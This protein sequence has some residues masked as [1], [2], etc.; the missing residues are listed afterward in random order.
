MSSKVSPRGVL[1]FHRLPDDLA[2]DEKLRFLASERLRGVEW[3]RLNPNA[4]HTWLRSDTEDEFESFIPIASKTARRGKDESADTIFKTYCLSMYTSRDMYVY[5]FSE[6]RLLDRMYDFIDQYNIEAFRYS[7]KNPKPEIDDF[8]SYDKIKWS[9][10]LKRE[11]ARGHFVDYEPS[12]VRVSHYRPY[13]KKWLYFDRQVNE[14]TYQQGT[15]FPHAQAELDNR[16][17]CCTDVSYRSPLISAMVVN[18]VPNMNVCSTTDAHQCFPF[19]TYDRDGSNRRENIT[20]FALARFRER[21]A[22]PRIGKWDIF[23]YVYALLHHPG[24]RARYAL[25]LKRSLP[26]LPFAPDFHAFAE[27][28]RRLADL[29]LHYERAEPYPLEWDTGGKTI[30]FRVER[31]RPG[32]KRAAEDGDWKVFDSLKYNDTLTLRGIPER[33]FAYRLGNRSALEWV[34]DQWRVK[35]DKRSGI[36]HDAN[37]YSDDEQYV[38]RLVERVV[39]VSLKTMDV[40]DGLAGL[41]FR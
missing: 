4:K 20:D 14:E 28:G 34:V 3:Q 36:T 29:H 17:I 2:K 18:V 19:Y 12:K 26:R 13:T 39:A 15:F 35:H 5:D 24:Y 27:A 9:R 16:A 8:V 25:D 33:A 1:H 23:Y 6:Q 7:R 40:V 10:K 31:M 32:R 38:V 21:Y 41:G 37:D 30:D 11:L 22:D